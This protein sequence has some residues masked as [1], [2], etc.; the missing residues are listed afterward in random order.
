M[1]K[2]LLILFFL[3]ANNTIDAQVY[4]VATNGNDNGDG[5]V[6]QPF[7]TIKKG[8]TKL[9][10][11]DT[12]YLKQGRYYEQIAVNE[13][14]G[15]KSH[16]ITIA[17]APGE[18]VI[19][20]GTDSLPDNWQLVTPESRA[21]KLIQDAQW[22]RLKGKLYSLEL[23]NPI[24]SLIYNDKL[25]SDARWPNAR[26][27]DPWRLDRYMVLRRA[28]EKST[29]G[30][31]EDALSTKN[32]L[33]ES[34]TWLNYDRS[35]LNHRNETLAN[36]GVSFENSVAILSYAWGSWATDVEA[37]QAGENSF[38]YDTEFKN[39]GSI[40][41][42]A[43]GFLNNRIGWNKA[44]SKFKR[45]SHSGLSYF[46]MG[47]AALDIEE[48]WWYNQATSTLYF[49]P[50]DGQKPTAGSVR[51]KRRDYQL[52]AKNSQYLTISDFEFYGAAALLNEVENSVLQNSKFHFSA[53]QKFS[54]GNYDIPV[55]TKIVN[56]YRK[57]DRSILH[58]NVLKNN[59]FTYLDGNAFEGR[60]TGLTIDNILI[61]QTQQ[62]TLG[63]DSR[64]MSIDR[65]LLVR[66]VTISDVGA[67]VG[68][69]GGGLDSTYELNNITRFGGL[70]YDGSSLQM[71]GRKQFIYRYNWSHDHPKRSYRFDAG[72]YPDF[73]N[74]FGEMSYNVAWN[75][76]GGFAIK[77]DDHLIHNNLLI[78]DTG[79]QLFNMKRWASKNERTLVANN[80]VPYFSAGS[81]DWDKPVQK[82]ST[83]SAKVYT[84]SDF[85]LKESKS[86]KK[87]NQHKE[88]QFDDGN[89]AKK[90]KSV[91]L[92][93]D[94]NNY[95]QSA[96]LVL[97][98]IKNLDFR[99]KKDS[100]LID[101][102]YQIK[103]VDVPWK[104]IAIT[105]NKS[106]KGRTIDIG[107]YEF[108]APNYWIPGF[109]FNTASTPIPPLHAQSV[110]RDASLMW[111]GA[112]GVNKHQL[113]W[114]IN[115]EEL[116]IADKDS[117]AYKGEYINDHNVHPFKDKLLSGQKV[118][119][120]VDAVKGNGIIVKGDI[121]SFTAE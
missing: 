98:D 72:S 51:G 88:S 35:K 22:S 32:A 53:S 1:K 84:S 103:A 109:K 25:M 61:Y 19:L 64:S 17:A 113:Y 54:V 27:N 15:T 92:A 81:Y 76:P 58:G 115:Q 48:E 94:K 100:V 71:G 60:S 23:T 12:L 86:N 99:P 9:S 74:A 39:S 41:K 28:S 20:D 55:T 118:Y 13:K 31:I 62:T 8:V 11:G 50:P 26:W 120:R 110:K 59:Q 49:M 111:L 97:R 65:P 16:P 57:R 5:S 10:P 79:F 117:N 102:G 119:W 91:V 78:G 18:H 69:K 106:S 96:D 2:L 47:L 29:K 3:L 105:G 75:T 40:Q 90:R 34:K 56:K 82:K 7:L 80:I 36:T 116:R 66:R 112:Y 108:G 63:L 93:I 87:V 89:K 37:H 70:Q 43:K 4:F 21:G 67:S 30:K 85:W 77:G 38:T 33:A 14:R 46:L 114:S 44:K 6:R 107:P 83:K 45:S 42:E 52:V 68:I 95:H 101:A 104:N 24:Y 73:A 121:W